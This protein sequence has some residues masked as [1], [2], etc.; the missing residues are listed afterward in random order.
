MVEL[1]LQTFSPIVVEEIFNLCQSTYEFVENLEF[2]LWLIVSYEIY[3]LGMT[4]FPVYFLCCN[5]VI[6]THHIKYLY[7]K[8][9]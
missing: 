8:N 9:C 1:L 3:T 5:A 6:P 4:F 2:L 7:E